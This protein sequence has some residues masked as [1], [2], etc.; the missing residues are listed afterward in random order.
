MSPLKTI[1][2]SR[3]PIDGKKKASYSEGFYQALSAEKVLHLQKP[4]TF[5]GY[6]RFCMKGYVRRRYFYRTLLK[7][8]KKNRCSTDS[9]RVVSN[10]GKKLADNE[11]ILREQKYQKH[12]SDFQSK[13]V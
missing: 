3:L 13:F 10:K 8:F 12:F 2:P 6:L 5:I 9:W 4:A 11:E 7:A 1:H